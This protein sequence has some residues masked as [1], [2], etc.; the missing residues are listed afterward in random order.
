MMSSDPFGARDH[1]D[2]PSTDRAVMNA[3]HHDRRQQEQRFAER[4]RL[5]LGHDRHLRD[6]ELPTFAS[7]PERA[8]DR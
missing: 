6:I 3:A 4:E 7:L 2:R 5:N 8:A 1:H